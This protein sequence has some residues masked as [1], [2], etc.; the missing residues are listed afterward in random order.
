MKNRTGKFFFT[1][2]FTF[3]VLIFILTF[4]INFLYAEEEDSDLKKEREIGRK[5]VEQIQEQWPLT[6]DPAIESKLEMI[7]NKL[8]PYMQRRID[9]EVKL[10]KSE[11]LNAFCLPG[12]FIFFTTGILEKLETDSELAAVMAHEMIHADRKHSLRMAA[13]GN[14][15]TLGA[16]AVMLLSGGAMAPV[17]LAQVAQVA[18]TSSY[19]MELESEADRLGLE[20]L[21][22]SGY[23]PKGM[24]TL[25]ERFMAEEYKQP[26]HNYG[27]YM[28]HPESPK[29]LAA[30]VKI[31]HDKKIPI[32]RKYPLGL[33]R[34]EIKETKKKIQLNIDGLNVLTGNNN[35]EIK[36][37]ITKSREAIDKYFQLELAPYEIQV[38]NNAVYISNHFISGNVKGITKPEKVRENLL[39]AINLARAKHPT[40]KFFK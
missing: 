31:L 23:S 22:K 24:I 32:E 9:W 34:T 1:F 6:S 30:A 33:L 14:K 11:E 5:A 36:D 40:S 2:I 25:F 26:I 21:I 4:N 13:E 28:N 37:A 7:I 39:K 38:M 35:P 12:G 3:A 29:R 15:V 19:T 17:V 16:L 18:I 10:V 20:A 27:I 8:E